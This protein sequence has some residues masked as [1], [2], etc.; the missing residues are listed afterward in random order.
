MAAVKVNFH[1]FLPRGLEGLTSLAERCSSMGLPLIADIKLN[2]IEAT[3][4]EA[5]D[6]LFGG[7]FDA[8]IANPFVGLDEGLSEALASA[9]RKEKGV[10]LLV[11]MSHSGARGLRYGGRWGTDLHAVR[12]EGARL[13]TDGA[14]VSAKSIPI[15][16]RVREVLKDEQVILSPGVGVQGGSADEATRAGADYAIVGRSIVESDDPVG[17]LRALNRS[18]PLRPAGR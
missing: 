2:D 9:H 14:I 11:Y 18:V 4:L 13:G 15:L 8:V 3:N 10:I 6:L 17:A 5:V 1:L 7:G 16:R 12:R